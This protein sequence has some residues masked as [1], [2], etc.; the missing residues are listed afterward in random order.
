MKI[1]KSSINR[2][3]TVF[4]FTV[5]VVLFGLVS[6]SRLSLNLLPDITYPSL[7]IQTEYPGAAPAE[8]ENLITKPIEEA[9][10][11]VSGVVDIHSISRSGMSEVILEFLWQTN[12]DF[13]SLDVREKLDLITLPDDAEAPV[14]LRFDPSLDPIMR[15]GFFGK[16]NLIELRRVADKTIKKEL[17]SID[18][19]AAVKINGGLE[20]EIQ[21]E[22]DEGRLTSLGIPITTVGQRL[23][24]DN[25]NLAGGSL[26]QD[27]SEYLVRTLNEFQNVDEIRKTIVHS[28][29]GRKVILEDIANVYRG[30]KERDI[31]T[32]INGEESVEIAIYKEGDANTVTVANTVSKRLNTLRRTLPEGSE[33]KTVFDQ[34][35][36]IRNSIAD[37]RN[38]AIIGGLLA[39]FILFFFL[40]DGRSTS[41]I[42][43]SIP[44]SVV[45]TFFAMQQFDV[46]L[47]IMSLGGIALGVGM[48]VDNS[49]VV[50]ES[51]YR[52]RKEEKLSLKDAAFKGASEVGKAVTASTL[53]TIAVFL[54]IIFVEGVAGQLFRDQ[55]L[56]VTFSLLASLAVALTLIP[57]LS[58][59]EIGKHESALSDDPQVEASKSK[60]IFHKLSIAFPAFILRIIRKG[61]NFFGK[62]ILKVLQPLLNIFDHYF[63][64]LTEVYPN[65]IRKSLERKGLVLGSAASLLIIALL[66]IPLLGLELIPPLSQGEFSFEVRLP[67]GS[68][69]ERTDSTLRRM[70][71]LVKDDPRVDIF[72]STAGGSKVSQTSTGNIKNENVGQLH[73]VLKAKS[74]RGGE[75]EVIEELREKFKNIPDATFKFSRPSYFTFKTPIEVDIYGYNLKQLADVTNRLAKRL[76]EI[77]GLKDVKSSIEPG[78]PEV[79]V[80]FNRDRLASL[81]LDMSDVSDILKNKIKGEVATRFQ[82]EDRQIDILVRTMEDNRG[83]VEDIRN[84]AVSQI[85]MRPIKLTAIADV[86]IDRGPSEI[87]RISQQRAAVIT[88]NLSGRD[89]GSISD[90]IRAAMNDISI[91]VNITA[92]LSG[93]NEEMETSF[94][95]LRF[96][97]LLAIFLVYLVMASQ[98]ESL[99]HP[100]I[101]IFTV[102]LALIGAIPALFVTGKTISVVVLIGVIMLAGIVVNN[103]IV[104]VDYI[105]RLR[106][107]GMAKIEAI[108][109]AGQVRLRPILMTTATTVLGLLPM[110]IDIG[111]GA[112]IRAP[113]AITVIGGLLVSTI[114][115]LIVIPTVYAVVDRKE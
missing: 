79:Q 34:S 37:L 13:A 77:P 69:L 78:N 108:I 36:F 51:I 26:E 50:L 5:A 89:L 66:L 45:A 53:T 111:E 80:I 68:R 90:D 39:V 38:T 98:F 60:R 92:M 52:F 27:Q 82:E 18:G 95:S 24:E 83:T 48:L 10:G 93:Q 110:A 100:F 44:I 65:I 15:I 20:E 2:P 114:L 61:F 35:T 32:R 19:V 6:F 11:V 23:L 71:K 64:K 57:M 17:E 67:E 54:P 75:A 101:I 42:G 99:I 86:K 91:P 72:S 4:M 7:T 81:N 63:A 62:L 73:I 96:A 97:L 14:L 25:I 8:V 70:E 29:N 56:T 76:S 58:S 30:H 28:H 40:R 9:V 106:S 102:P 112:E 115:T 85:E 47:N 16:D 12:M 31:I 109:K 87:H 103:A 46:T 74:D 22:I 49:I 105:N 43:L 88:A 84:L 104:L 113:M 21:V 41:I 94:S 33:L 3:V 55:A 59:R 107:G 1:V